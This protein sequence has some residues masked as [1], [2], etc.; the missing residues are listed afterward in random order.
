MGRASQEFDRQ[1]FT[2]KLSEL[3]RQMQMESVKSDRAAAWQRS[4]PA[5]LGGSVSIRIVDGQLAVLSRWLEG[6][7]RICREVWKT[8]GETVTPEFVREILVPEAMTVIGAR[9]GVTQSSVDHNAVRTNRDPHAARHSLAIKVNRLKSEIANRYEIEAR[10]L[11][12]LAQIADHL[13]QQQP[14]VGLPEPIRPVN[15]ARTVTQALAPPKEIGGGGYMHSAPKPTRMPSRPDD[16]P[17][18]LWPRAVVTLSTLIEKFPNQKHLRELCEHAVPEMTPLYCEAVETGKVEPG[19]V[20]SDDSGMEELLRLLLAANDPGHS[21]WGISN[22]AWEILQGAKTATWGKLAKAIAEV[23]Q[24]TANQMKRAP[25]VAPKT[26]S[27]SIMPDQFAG[28]PSWEVTELMQR[29]V[30]AAGRL[31]TDEKHMARSPDPVLDAFNRRDT[32]VASE[33]THAQNSD[34]TATRTKAKPIGR[35]RKDADR[36]LIRKLKAEGNSWKEIAAK[37]NAQ[38]GQNKSAEAYRGLLKSRSGVGKN[39]QK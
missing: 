30:E 11:E 38:N 37:A 32:G 39:E 8:Q 13:P 6:V 36:E 19:A 4:G 29:R 2:L 3:S 23:Q 26:Q 1:L 21:S 28:L 14:H 7:D 34:K 20:L 24:R 5:K 22:Q 33:P 10:E 17:S 31:R 35:P 16:F 27:T 9:V 18:D 15:T 25:S 12:N